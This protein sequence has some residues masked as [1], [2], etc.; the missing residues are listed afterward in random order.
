MFFI[1]HR[2][3]ILGP[4]KKDENK[5]DNSLIYKGICSDYIAKYKKKIMV[6]K[7]K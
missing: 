2:G 6:L 4:N 3:N 1:P 5:F 7:K